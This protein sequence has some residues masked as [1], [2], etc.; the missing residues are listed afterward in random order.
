LAS[1][2]YAP[3]QTQLQQAQGIES[4]GQSALDIGAQ[5]GGRNANPTGANALYQGG[6]AAA[7]SMAAANAYNPMAT[8]LQGIGQNKDFTNALS[9]MFGGNPYGGFGSNFNSAAAQNDYMAGVN[10]GRY[11]AG[12]W[13][14]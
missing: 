8:A 13:G 14:E 7:A 6:N 3:L 1:G 11:T 10:S 12:G 5:L 4:L 9:G 2:A